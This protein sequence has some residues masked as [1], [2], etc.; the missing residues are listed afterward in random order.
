VVDRELAKDRLVVADR[1]L[2]SAPLIAFPADVARDVE[3]E[4]GT[5]I[6]ADATPLLGKNR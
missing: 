4:W 6:G 5:A 2:G 1:V 3:A